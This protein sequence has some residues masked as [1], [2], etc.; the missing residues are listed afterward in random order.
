VDISEIV[1][2]RYDPDGSG[3]QNVVSWPPGREFIRRGTSATSV[4]E[5][6]PA[7]GILHAR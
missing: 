7:S 3:D 5:P 2:I 1:L 6:E 4:G